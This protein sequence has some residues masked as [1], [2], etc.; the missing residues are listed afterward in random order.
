M[1]ENKV[2][3]VLVLNNNNLKCLNA[4]KEIK[5]KQTIE[6]LVVSN[7]TLLK[8][9][10]EK[11]K[12]L[13]KSA[14]TISELTFQN[15]KMEQ[16]SGELLKA[17]D[18]LTFE[19]ERKAE[20]LSELIMAYEGL[21][22]QNEKKGLQLS[23]LIIAYEGLTFENEL[24]DKQAEKQLIA[25]SDILNAEKNTHKLKDENNT[26]LNEILEHRILERAA[27]LEAAN[28]ELEAFSYSVSHDLRAP[29]RAI[30][31]HALILREDYG[32][33]LD[34][35]GND[36]INVLIESSKKMGRLI[37]DLLKFSQLGRLE[38]VKS[39][40]NM[41]TIVEEIIKEFAFIRDIGK[42]HFSINKL[43]RCKGDE[44][45]LKQVWFNL[46]D[47]A[48]KYAGTKEHPVVEIDCNEEKNLLIYF[49]KDNGVGFDMAYQDKLFGVFQ[50]LHSEAEFEG[51]GLGLSLV[52][53]IIEK[54]KGRVFAE[55]ILNEGS[56]FYFTIPK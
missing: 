51:T 3:E 48:L 35:V 38:A 9:N 54:H 16:L 13:E 53:R 6:E 39:S 49:I 56:T 25:T 22:Y 31:G 41:N 32:H 45:M 46:I 36:S 21:N 37:D 44:K 43:P 5:E 2:D 52:K 12:L 33:V 29:L 42:Y 24:K 17:N 30:S 1:D 34:K 26:K 8:L 55:S 10:L 4:L 27:E 11:E 7:K 20:E 28:S 18:G 15:E 40:V 50:R 23:E 47:N 19:N 14:I